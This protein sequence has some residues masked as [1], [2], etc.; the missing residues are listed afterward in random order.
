M[1]FFNDLPR[2]SLSTLRSIATPVL[3]SRA[4]AEGGED[5]G[6]GGF[7]NKNPENV[8]L[9]SERFLTTDGQIGIESG[10]Y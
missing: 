1:L 4:T 5:G 3:R 6:E 10:I 8:T 9:A 7:P 2:R